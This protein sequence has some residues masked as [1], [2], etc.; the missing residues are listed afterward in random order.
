MENIERTKSLEEYN[1][2]RTKIAELALS[3]SKEHSKDI[4]FCIEHII[5][6]LGSTSTAIEIVENIKNN[7]VPKKG[8]PMNVVMSI[9]KIV[10]EMR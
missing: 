4:S 9:M 2:I 5:V 10:E 3:L 8:C 1:A 7:K 6:G